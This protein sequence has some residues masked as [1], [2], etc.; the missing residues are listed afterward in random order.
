MTLRAPRRSATRPA[1][2]AVTAEAAGLGVMA[3]PACT[4]E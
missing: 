1:H 3:S 2:S 4:S